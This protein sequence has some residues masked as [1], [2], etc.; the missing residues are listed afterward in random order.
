M[1][2]VQLLALGDLGRQ[3]RVGLARHKGGP[4]I[5]DHRGN[6]GLRQARAEGHHRR[7][8]VP[9]VYR[10]QHP[11]ARQIGAGPGSGEI[12]R[13]G[14]QAAAHPGITVPFVTVADHAVLGIDQG[15]V[16]GRHGPHR[17]RQ[18]GGG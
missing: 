12:R 18:A 7:A 6:L 5:V 8:G 17:A 9:P 3:G 10:M 13:R 1:A 15:A 16:D 4:D 14:T 11:L 2:Y